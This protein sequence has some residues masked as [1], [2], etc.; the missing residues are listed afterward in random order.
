VVP[1]K[2]RKAAHLKLGVHAKHSWYVP[3]KHDYSAAAAFPVLDLGHCC[4]LSLRFRNLEFLENELEAY[5]QAE[6]EKLEA[7]ERRLKKMQKR[8]A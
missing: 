8:L 6:Q 5:Y 2:S 3:N 1:P 4:S 7:Q